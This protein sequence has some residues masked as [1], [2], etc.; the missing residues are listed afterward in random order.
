MLNNAGVSRTVEVVNNILDLKFNKYCLLEMYKSKAFIR[1]ALYF[2][3]LLLV[4]NHMN[5]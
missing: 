2:F 1:R 3:L 5:E 4:D